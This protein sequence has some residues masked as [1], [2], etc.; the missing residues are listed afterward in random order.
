MKAVKELNLGFSD[1]QNYTKRDNK[2]MLADVFVKNA[3]LDNLLKP[4]TYYLVG[5][6]E[7][8]KLHMQPI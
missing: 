3:Y 5:E 2:Q 8:G 4:S 7:L 6:K 1:A